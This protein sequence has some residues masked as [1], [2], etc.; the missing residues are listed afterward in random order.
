MGKTRNLSVDKKIEL[1]RQG[2]GQDLD[3][4]VNDKECTVRY[5]VARQGR[6]KDLDILI[7]DKDAL[8]LY[9]VLI[10]KRLVDIERL[11]ARIKNGEFNDIRSKMEEIVFNVIKN[12]IK[13]YE[14]M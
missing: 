7:N 5:E 14:N 4:L 10:H 13:E 12:I 2:R 1:A 6:N 11:K 8:V 3:I 9:G